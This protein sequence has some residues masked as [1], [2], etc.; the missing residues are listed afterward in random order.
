MRT[1]RGWG[2]LA[3]AIALAGSLAVP[4]RADLKAAMAEPNLEKRSKLALDNAE[5][6]YQAVRAAYEKG[7]NT[8][9]AAAAKEILESVDLAYTS[10]T[11]TGKDPRRSPKWFKRAEIET[12]DLLRRLTGF[13]EQMSFDD[14]PLLDAAKTRLQQVHDSLL[15]GLMEGKHK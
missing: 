13:Q 4:L 14:R 9:V 15:V 3:A 2:A 11:A 8:Q 12:R 5:T 7:D 10:L 6:A 1:V